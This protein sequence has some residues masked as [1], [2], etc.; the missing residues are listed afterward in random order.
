MNPVQLA[1]NLESLPALVSLLRYVQ[2][3]CYKHKEDKENGERKSSMEKKPTKNTVRILTEQQSTLDEW[4]PIEDEDA[5]EETVALQDLGRSD[6][7]TWPTLPRAVSLGGV[8][9]LHQD[10]LPMDH[11][12]RLI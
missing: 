7:D 10:Q 3:V 12:A 4:E 9:L 2:E 1:A 11:E 5:E 8:L 6:I